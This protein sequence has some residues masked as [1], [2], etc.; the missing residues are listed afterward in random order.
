[1]FPGLGTLFRKLCFLTPPYSLYD[2]RTDLWGYAEQTDAGIL[3]AYWRLPWLA[4][5]IAAA[6]VW[7]SVW[8]MYR[9]MGSLVRHANRNRR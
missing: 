1:M 2:F 7:L 6:W 9:A 4:Y 8:V 5:P 3:A